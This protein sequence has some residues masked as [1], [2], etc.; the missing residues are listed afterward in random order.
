MK[1]I[2]GLILSFV[3]ML[4]IIPATFADDEIMITYNGEIIETDTSPVI[5]DGRTLVPARAVFE[6]MG[7]AVD[8]DG[9]T[10]T[11]SVFNQDINIAITNDVMVKLAFKAD[12]SVEYKDIALE[13]PAQIINDRTMIPVRAVSEAMDI[14]VDWDDET[15]TVIL[16]DAGEPIESEAPS[17]TIEPTFEDRLKEYMP[18][19]E[20]YMISPMSIKV[21]LAM[22]ANGADEEIQSEMLDVLDISNLDECNEGIKA[23]IEEYAEMDAE[24]PDADVNEYRSEPTVFRLANSIWINKDGQ[25]IGPNAE[26]EDEFKDTI[27]DYYYGEADSVTNKDGAKKINAWVSDATSGRIA[28]IITDKDMPDIEVAL[29]NAVYMKAAWM[30]KFDEHMT[31]PEVFTDRDGKETEIDFMH[32]QMSVLY[33]DDGERKMIVLPY[34]DGAS[35]YIVTGSATASEAQ[36]YLEQAEYKT[37]DVAIPKWKTEN[38]FDLLET[39]KAMGIKKAFATLNLNNSMLKNA[40]SG[41]FINKLIQK[42]YIDVD[43]NGTEAAAVTFAGAGGASMPTE[44]MEFKADKPFTYFIYDMNDNLMFMGEYAYAE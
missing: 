13:V 24:N 34:A 15:R 25:Y 14:N 6:T 28:G 29:V 44:I 11:V 19:D 17:E 3:M 41:I 1:R 39:A 38:T 42:T 37:V 27:T 16:T 20:N 22:Y 7:F 23:I 30:H 31:S 12:G 33:Y 4:S 8:W 5:I 2:S 32:K 21:A 9:N 43:E 26:F 35:M 18:A 10:G 40:A 36:Q